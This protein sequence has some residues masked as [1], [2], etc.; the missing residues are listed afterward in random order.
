ML[1]PD[2]ASHF[3]LGAGQG[4]PSSETGNPT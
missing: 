3:S 1:D 2:S 4:F